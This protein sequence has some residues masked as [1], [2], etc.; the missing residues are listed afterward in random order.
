MSTSNPADETVRRIQ[1]LV[2]ATL[3]LGTPYLSDE[4]T[5]QGLQSMAKRWRTPALPVVV[6][7][8]VARGKST[9]INS[10]LGRRLLPADFRPTTAAWTRVR[11]GPALEGQAIVQEA[12]QVVACPFNTEE[13]FRTY[14]TIAGEA[15]FLD[16]HGDEARVLSVNLQTPAEILDGGLELIDT[17]GVGGLWAAHRQAALAALAE[18][19]AV[20]FVLKPGEPISASERRFLAEAVERVESCVI[21]QTHGDLD[22]GS[23][24]WLAEDMATLTDAAEWEALLGDAARARRLCVLFDRV[25]AVSVSPENALA[26]LESGGAVRRALLE[27]SGIG[28]LREIV[29]KE[30]V[31]RGAELHRRNVLRL[32]ELV[33]GAVE[34]RA[35]DQIA[36]LSDEGEAA[37]AVEE[38]RAR[39]SRWV[40]HNGDLWRREFDNA[41]KR[42]LAG[43][44]GIADRRLRGLEREYGQQLPDLKPAEIEELVPRL[45]AEP[46]EALTEM[47][48]YSRAEIE[49]SAKRV[50]N[51]MAEGGLSGPLERLQ[52]TSAVF[53]RLPAEVSVDTPW[54]LGPDDA[55]QALMGGMTGTGITAAAALALQHGGWLASS[56]IASGPAAPIVVPFLIGGAVFVAINQQKRKRVRARQ[57]ATQILSDV[58]DEITDT[59]L[60]TARDVTLATHRTVAEQISESLRELAA[61]VERDRDDLRKAGSRTPAERLEGIARHE[62][63][64]AA[65]QELLAE[66]R[67]LRDWEESPA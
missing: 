42:T 57:L 6:A 51:L 45:M 16:R 19:D 37:R 40:E 29:Q 7:G 5:L 38:R 20:I 3:E 35:S 9:L 63:A 15:R 24:D 25:R 64:L 46:E 26:A 11:G 41:C 8:E 18:A 23:R 2:R 60:R 56:T 34:S 14:I 49:K 52:Q 47:V 27:T 48:Q 59:A 12:G 31:A 32:V 50:R 65:V 17:P 1:D 54:R 67:R 61:Q 39:I 44:R 53:A 43:L 55:R 30:I 36:F 10:L 58:R 33:L 4:R 22:L 62:G 28:L 21:V 13:D 66:M